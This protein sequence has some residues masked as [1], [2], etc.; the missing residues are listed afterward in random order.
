MGGC[1]T[2][3]KVVGKVFSLRCGTSGVVENVVSILVIE[4][5]LELEV[6]DGTASMFKLLVVES[7]AS[8]SGQHYLAA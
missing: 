4:R 5:A 7:P 2:G 6:S 8:A 3:K 1:A